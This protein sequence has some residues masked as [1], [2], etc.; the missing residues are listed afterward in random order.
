MKFGK[1]L[2]LSFALVLGFVIV[3]SIVGYHVKPYPLEVRQ[4]PLPL[5]LLIFLK[6]SVLFALVLIPFAGVAIGIVTEVNTGI[7][8]GQILEARGLALYPSLIRLFTVGYFFAVIEL[9]AFSI[10]L[11][12]TIITTTSIIRKE[13]LKER[14]KRNVKYIILGIGLLALSAMLETRI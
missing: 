2:V 13:S 7:L 12:L 5:P 3:G 1:T 6:N 8:V 11:T 4:Y 9:L 14:L 10:A